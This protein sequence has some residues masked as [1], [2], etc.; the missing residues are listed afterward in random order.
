MTHVCVTEVEYDHLKDEY[1]LIEQIC[2][3]EE[4]IH[5]PINKHN[6]M[7]QK[8][9]TGGR[10]VVLVFFEGKSDPNVCHGFWEFVRLILELKDSGK[11]I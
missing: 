3:W 5:N 4:I 10:P 8:Y 7:Y 1:N 9:Y 11:H 6:L 2:K